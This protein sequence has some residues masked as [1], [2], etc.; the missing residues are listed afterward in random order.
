MSSSVAGES[1]NILAPVTIEF[2]DIM[3][4]S[5][6]DMDTTTIKVETKIDMRKNE[7]DEEDEDLEYLRLNCDRLNDRGATG[8][9]QVKPGYLK[10]YLN[11]GYL[12]YL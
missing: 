5:E 2:D 7:K 1:F 9:S 11:L 8:F 3:A 6:S 10:C 12:L 4:A